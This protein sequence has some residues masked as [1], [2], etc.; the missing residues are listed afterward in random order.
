MCGVQLRDREITTELMLV[1]GLNE[2]RD[3]LANS[4]C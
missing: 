1:L 3:Q 2:T 4:I